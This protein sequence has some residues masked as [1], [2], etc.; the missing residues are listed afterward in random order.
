VKAPFFHEPIVMAALTAL[1][2]LLVFVSL[3]APLASALVTTVVAAGA[4][5]YAGVTRPSV[6]FAYPSLCLC[7][8]VMLACLFGRTFEWGGRRYRWRGTF[9]VELVGEST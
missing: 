9:D 2:A 5:R 1:W 8:L 4:Y 7:P 3:F 6:V